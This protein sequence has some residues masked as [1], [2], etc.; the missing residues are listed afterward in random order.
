MQIYE[1]GNFNEKTSINCLSTSSCSDEKLRDTDL[2]IPYKNEKTKQSQI[3][4]KWSNLVATIHDHHN[5]KNVR[6]LRGV[7]GIAKPG[8]LTCLI[9]SSGAGKTTLLNILGKRSQKEVQINEN[10]PANSKLE[11]CEVLLN[12][13]SYNLDTFKRVGA[14]LE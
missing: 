2:D 7:S 13:Q 8:E 3:W 10:L 9:G 6:I 1:K 14:Y 11:S 12:G 5:N 4:V